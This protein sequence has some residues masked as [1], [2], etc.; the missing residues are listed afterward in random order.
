MSENCQKPVNYNKTS[1]NYPNCVR[2]LSEIYQIQNCQKYVL[3]DLEMSE[4]KNVRELF[5]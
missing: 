3:P 5:N 2:Y 1:G 4:V